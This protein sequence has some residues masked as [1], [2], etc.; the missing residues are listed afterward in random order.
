MKRNKLLILIL[1]TILL[2]GCKRGNTKAEY[3]P[4]DKAPK[5]L[6]ELSSGID[7]ILRAVD[8]IEKLSLNIPS[9]E[10]Q[11]QKQQGQQQKNT[12]G[13]SDKVAGGQDG[14]GG[15][16]G[17]GGSSGGN[18]GGGGSGGSA[19]S[20]GGGGGGSD[21]QP[22]GQQQKPPSKEEM[23][24]NSWD[25][26]Q[27]KLEDVHAKWNAYEAEGMKKGLTKESG[28]KFE[29]SINTLTKAAENKNIMEIY[30]S[31]SNSYLNLKPFYDL[32]QD[33][34]SGDIYTIKY[35][36]NQAYLKAIQGDLDAAISLLNGREENINKIRLKQSK[37]EEKEKTE[38]VSLSLADFRKALEENSRHL[39]MIKKDVIVENLKNIE[40]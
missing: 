25:K 15:G 1:F 13:A 29:A 26:I 2:F 31:A 40:E 37:D 16:T 8:E 39:F 19:G 11:Q 5:S 6:K 12:G 36:A 3:K 28:D 30:D 24:K 4:K 10:Q 17:G 20:S 9:K 18:G 23:I 14:S 22:S 35:A 33:E 7:E 38:K 21:Q 34:V 27:L 32:Y